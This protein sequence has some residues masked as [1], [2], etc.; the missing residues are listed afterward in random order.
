MPSRLPAVVSTG[1]VLQSAGAG[2]DVALL[3]MVVVRVVVRVVMRV[4]VR[5]VRVVI[6]V[7][8]NRGT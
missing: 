5:V 8:R 4:V 6:V 7:V 1:H 3:V 2:Q